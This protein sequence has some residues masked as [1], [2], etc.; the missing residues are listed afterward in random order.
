MVSVDK[1]SHPQKPQYEKVV[2]VVTRAVAK[3]NIEWPTGK[4]AELQKSK[5]DECFL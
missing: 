1:D 5:V 3:L 2:E 4:Q